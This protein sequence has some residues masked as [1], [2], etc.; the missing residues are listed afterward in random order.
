M[1]VSPLC[2]TMKDSQ[3]RTLYDIILLIKW[4]LFYLNYDFEQIALPYEQKC[5][6]GRGHPWQ[7][8]NPINIFTTIC[9][10][11]Y[12]VTVD[13]GWPNNSWLNELVTKFT[14]E[15][16]RKSSSTRAKIMFR[17]KSV[18]WRF[19]SR[20]KIVWSLGI[21]SSR[22]KNTRVCNSLRNICHKHERRQ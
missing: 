4:L 11:S 1:K 14:G 19:L 8:T 2:E 3:Q 5:Q 20:Q 18:L 6:Q 9:Y 12:T 10:I 7:A 21:K 16:L 15:M 13:P 17:Q 22:V